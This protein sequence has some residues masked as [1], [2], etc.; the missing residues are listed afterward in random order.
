MVAMLRKGAPMYPRAA[1]AMGGLAVGSI[2]NAGLQLYHAGDISVMVLI[3]DLG[4][5]A[6]LS[7][8]AAWAG[9]SILRWPDAASI[10]REL[11]RR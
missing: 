7:A 5:V 2:A 6:I 4:S 1:L 3:C 11:S 8:I 9:R 10:L